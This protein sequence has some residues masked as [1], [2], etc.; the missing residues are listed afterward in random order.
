MSLMSKL[1]MSSTVATMVVGATGFD[2]EKFV[3][4]NVIKNPQVKVNKITVMSTKEIPGN[5]LW[6]A[7]LL[8]ADLKFKGKDLKEPMTIFVDEKDNLATMSLLNAK[9]G[10]DYARVL[11]PTIPADMYNDAHLM[12]GNK[13]AKH[14][15]VLFS[16]PQCPFCIR[17]VPGLVKEVRANPNNL[18]VYYYHMPLTRLHPVSE[19]LTRVMEVLQKEGKKDLAL[20]IY[21][22]KISPRE[23]NEDKILAAL[24][25]QLN[26]V[27]TKEAISKPEIKEAVKKDMESAVKMMV[28]GTPTVYFDGEYDSTRNRYK[29][30]LK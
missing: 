11:K 30:F 20:K 6:K 19:V 23:T 17:F 3:K 21:S 28:R 5:S 10:M 2:I 7:Y 8:T 13:D 15:L 12:L 29:A 22:L 14:K 16:D 9:T 27:V 25:K 1:L 4:T 18:A 24:K 26:I